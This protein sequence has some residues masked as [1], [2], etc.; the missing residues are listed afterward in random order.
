M[1]AV[2]VPALNEYNAGVLACQEDAFTLAFYALGDDGLAA[3]VVQAAVR[4]AY[5]RFDGSEGRCREQILSAVAEGCWRSTDR[6]PADQGVFS[7]LPIEERLAVI[8]VDVLGLSY[9]QAAEILRRPATQFARLLA[10]GRCKA[11]N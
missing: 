9:R 6:R 4:Q 7:A 8:L 5:W 10:Q 11:G 2:P 1:H 3:Q